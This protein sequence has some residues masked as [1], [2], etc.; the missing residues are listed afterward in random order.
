MLA[1]FTS[2]AFHPIYLFFSLPASPA[3]Y[4]LSGLHLAAPRWRLFC[5]PHHLSRFWP[6]L[7]TP[8]DYIQGRDLIITPAPVHPAAFS[9]WDE[10]LELWLSSYHSVKVLLFDKCPV[11]I[12]DQL[13]SQ[14]NRPCHKGNSEKFIEDNFLINIVNHHALSF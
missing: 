13:K 3:E 9:L 7:H 12:H 11:S 10:D 6:R 4:L 14:R 1:G 5:S 8:N 2:L